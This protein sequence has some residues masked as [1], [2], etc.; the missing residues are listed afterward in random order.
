MGES[1]PVKKR[2]SGE[3]SSAANTP[4]NRFAPQQFCGFIG[5]AKLNGLNPE[6]YLRQQERTAGHPVNKF[7]EL[8]S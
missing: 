5:T 7:G 8:L 3:G 6:A 1:G 4:P 2:K